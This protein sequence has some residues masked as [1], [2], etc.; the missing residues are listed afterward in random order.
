MT[1]VPEPAAAVS[2][3]PPDA[4]SRGAVEGLTVAPGQERFVAAPAHYLD[5]CASG[6]VWQPWAVHDTAA[7]DAVVGFLMWA[8]DDEDG[9]VW[10]GGLFVDAA[11][12]GRGLGRAAVVAALDVLR[13]RAGAA[14]FALAY[15]PANTVARGL[16]ASLGFVETG[17]VDDDEVVARLLSA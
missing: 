3:R 6:G 1:D 7:T 15:H 16:Y 11:H 2:L 17:E 8:V 13:D 9:S 4:V 14:G 5:L 10:L 12:Q